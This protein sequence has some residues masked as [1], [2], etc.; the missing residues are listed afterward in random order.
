MC[1]TIDKRSLFAERIDAFIAH[2]K[3]L[4][5]R[6][7]S[8]KALMDRFDRFCADNYASESSLILELVETWTSKRVILYSQTKRIAKA[9]KKQKGI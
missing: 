2:K 5:N 8:E 6:Y 1:G 3:A 4:G 7:D 9:V